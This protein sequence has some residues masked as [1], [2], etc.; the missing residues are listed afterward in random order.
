ML[1]KISCWALCSRDAAT[2]ASLATTTAK[3][4]LIPDAF[5]NFN[6]TI[7]VLLN[8]PWRQSRGNSA[9]AFSACD[10]Q[11]GPSAV[12][13][14]I[15]AEA[16]EDCTMDVSFLDGLLGGGN[17]G[18]FQECIQ[19]EDQLFEEYLSQLAQQPDNLLSPL[20]SLWQG[21]RCVLSGG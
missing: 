9:A 10:P 18:P 12:Q 2:S 17:S 4:H 5:K 19:M 3:A 8:I 21:V 14:L 6:A 20:D 7:C 15:C 16:P 1:R 13:H 11:F